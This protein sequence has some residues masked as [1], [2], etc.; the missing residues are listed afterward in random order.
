MNIIELFQHGVQALTPI[1]QSDARFE[2]NCLFE[3]ATGISASQRLA[4]PTQPVSDSGQARFSALLER[5]LQGEPL[6]YI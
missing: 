2:C 1:A 3:F 6:Q 4:N 5:R